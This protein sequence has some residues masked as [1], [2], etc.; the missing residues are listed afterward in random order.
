MNLCP[1]L[2]TRLAL[3][4]LY[5]E[6]AGGNWVEHKGWV[7]GN[8]ATH[9]YCSAFGVVCG[10]G[11]CEVTRLVLGSNNLSGPITTLLGDLKFLMD[12]DLRNNALSGTIPTEISSLTELVHL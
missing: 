4:Q 2:E 1:P 7:T 10:Y 6:T 5:T 11:D 9:S 3:G 12:L 8:P